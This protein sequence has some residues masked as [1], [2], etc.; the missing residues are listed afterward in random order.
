MKPVDRD[1]PDD[2]RDQQQKENDCSDEVTPI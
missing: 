2:E 1:L